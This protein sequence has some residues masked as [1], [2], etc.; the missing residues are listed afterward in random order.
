[1]SEKLQI[2]KGGKLFETKWIYDKEKKEGHYEDRD[3]T[4]HAYRF[5]FDIC[6]LEEGITLKDMITK[7]Q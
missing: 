1:M 3:V 7:F 2:R 6:D 5:L 4:D